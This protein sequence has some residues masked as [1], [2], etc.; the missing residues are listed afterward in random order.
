MTEHRVSR[1]AAAS[2]VLCAVA[3]WTSGASL[4]ASQD[5]EWKFPIGVTYISGFGDVVDYHETR[6]GVPADLAVPVGVQFTPYVQYA[7]G[8]RIGMNVGP[9]TGIFAQVTT[10]D[11]YST[12][13][14]NYRYADIPIGADYGFTFLPKKA[15]SPYAA[16]GFRYHIA[17]GDFVGSS[18][19]G[20]YG[21]IGLEFARKNRVRFGFELAYD[22]S[23]LTLESADH[24]VVGAPIVLPET[25]VKPCEVMFG[26]RVIL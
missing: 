4:A 26:F 12:S 1:F 14:Q 17:T 23:E 19:A 25:T 7:H 2:F 5:H 11:G 16:V 10:F 24:D 13:E 15:V 3:G 22:G 6:F 9:V 20:L 8:S 21:A 18:S